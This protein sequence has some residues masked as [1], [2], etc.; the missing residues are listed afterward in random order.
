MAI[1]TEQVLATG[2]RLGNKGHSHVIGTPVGNLLR[3]HVW[4]EHVTFKYAIPLKSLP[5]AITCIVP[6][7]KVPEQSSHLAVW[8]HES[9][10]WLNSSLELKV[11][12]IYKEKSKQRQMDAENVKTFVIS[13][14]SQ[15]TPDASPRAPRARR[16]S[17]RVSRPRRARL[18]TRSQTRA[19]LPLPL[20]SSSC[21]RALALLDPGTRR[22]DPLG[23]P[24]PRR[25]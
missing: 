8:Q 14:R 23:C 6:I 11:G 13:R 19:S 25:R 5:I 22:R 17:A 15:T 12:Y 3:R 7:Q 9:C 10:K 20:S 4:G 2:H 24:F 1:I 18:T 21:A 16:Y